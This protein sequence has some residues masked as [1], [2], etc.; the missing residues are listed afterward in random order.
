M[1]EVEKEPKEKL[2]EKEKHNEENE[3]VSW[4]GEKSRGWE[5]HWTEKDKIEGSE[6]NENARANAA[7]KLLLQLK[8]M[9]SLRFQFPVSRQ[10]A[11]AHK[12]YNFIGNMEKAFMKCM[13]LSIQHAI[14]WTEYSWS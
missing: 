11:D 3:W 8:E 1:E 7:Q 10:V 14:S 12:I 6:V 4:R 2:Y 5:K 13:K 9:A